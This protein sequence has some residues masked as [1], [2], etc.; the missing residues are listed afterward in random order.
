[1]TPESAGK[2]Q[3]DPIQPPV[4]VLAL[5]ALVDEAPDVAPAPI[6][7]APA[8]LVELPLLPP[9]EVAPVAPAVG[10]PLEAALLEELVLEDGPIAPPLVDP[11]PI[12]EPT[13]LLVVVPPVFEAVVEAA[14]DVELFAL[15][16]ATLWKG[17]LGEQLLPIAIKLSVSSKPAHPSF[18]FERRMSSPRRRFYAQVTNPSQCE[19]AKRISVS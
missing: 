10:V 14:P 2:V 19:R 1:M 15:A 13:A 16:D 6:L 17:M 12:E 4:P 18:L 7:V 11:A 9:N 3:P 8:T 5:E